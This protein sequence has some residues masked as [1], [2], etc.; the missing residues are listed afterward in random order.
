M[1]FQV[2]Y[3]WGLFSADWLSFKQLCLV[4]VCSDSVQW[5]FTGSTVFFTNLLFMNVIIYISQPE[6]SS[7]L[8]W[9][10]SGRHFR[11]WHGI[12]LWFQEQLTI[13]RRSAD[14]PKKH[15]HIHPFTFHWIRCSGPHPIWL[16]TLPGMRHPQYLE[17]YSSLPILTAKNFTVPF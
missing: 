14:A 2:Y 12:T 15:T 13:P 7:L 6:P 10:G 16:R 5:R 3:I 9:W 11:I 8:R 4:F 17:T 1:C